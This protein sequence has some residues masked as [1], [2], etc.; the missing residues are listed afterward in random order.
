MLEQWQ[1]DTDIRTYR[2]QLQYFWR[3]IQRIQVQAT[4]YTHISMRQI[5]RKDDA[6]IQK[7]YPY[8]WWRWNTSCMHDTTSI[9]HFI[10]IWILT[11]IIIV[12]RVHNT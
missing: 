1:E 12:H 4:K 11:V 2:E 7:N 9:G 8:L 6:Y 5:H 10:L 3:Y